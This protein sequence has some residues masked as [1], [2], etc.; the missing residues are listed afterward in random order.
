MSRAVVIF[1][2]SPQRE[3]L[4]KRLRIETAAPLFRSLTEAWIAAAR[5]H[6][7]TPIVA[8]E[9]LITVEAMHIPQRGHRF[10]ARVA[11][12]AADAHALGFTSVVIAAIDAPPPA[13][14][15]AAFEALEQGSV[16]IAPAR[17]GGVNLIGVGLDELAFLAAIV[18]RQRDLVAR[19]RA[20]F[21]QL[22]VLEETVDVDDDAS[23]RLVLDDGI[24]VPL[25]IVGATSDGVRTPQQSRA[26]PAA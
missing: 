19:C 20:H 4:A 15:G 7:A 25:P 10:G 16:V 24:I 26:P 1:A 8:S 18:P 9:E 21:E 22:V 5:A 3:A 14:L 2:R 17:D 6:G 11:A 13:A 23:L 12:A